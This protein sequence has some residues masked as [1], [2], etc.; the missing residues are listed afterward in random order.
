MICPEVIA[1]EMGA[2]D[3]VMVAPSCNV[4]CAQQHMGFAGTITLRP[5]TM[6]AALM[7]WVN[8]LYKHGFTRFYFLNGHGG[9]TDS[10]AVVGL[11]FVNRLGH[12]VTIATGAY[13]DIARP[14][15]TDQGLIASNLV[16]GHAG[17]FETA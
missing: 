16:P 5:S 14:S 1:R 2:Q 17:Q 11:D 4:G 3:G 8:S 15:L 13:W 6:V 7:D 10:N 9:N 12:P